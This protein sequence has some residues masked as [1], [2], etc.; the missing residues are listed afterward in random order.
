MNNKEIRHN[1]TIA[2]WKFIYCIMIII[3]HT[4]LHIELEGKIDF[5][6][7]AI[8]VEFFF[9]VSGYLLGKKALNYKNL[10]KQNLGEETFF[11]L[12]IK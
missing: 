6:Y 8:G 5:K 1:G 11:I 9:L 12:R 10:E 7:G 2:L 3:Y 4:S